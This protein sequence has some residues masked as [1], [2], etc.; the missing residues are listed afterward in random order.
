MI[1]CVLLSNIE[2][3]RCHRCTQGEG[4]IDNVKVVAKKH[5]AD[6]QEY[7]SFR[8]TSNDYNGRYIGRN[9]DLNVQIADETLWSATSEESSTAAGNGFRLLVRGD[10]NDGLKAMMMNGDGTW[11][12]AWKSGNPGSDYTPLSNHWQFFRTDELSSDA[13][14]QYNAARLQL[15]QYL[16]EAL[17]QYGRGFTAVVPAY[18]S[19]IVIYNNESSTIEEINAAVE[20]VA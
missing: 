3:V 15:Y 9:N 5:I 10:N 19:G 6:G 14:K 20:K 16:R 17:Q 13:I 11:V 7:W 4:N 12:V 8:I 1:Y 2:T 18:N